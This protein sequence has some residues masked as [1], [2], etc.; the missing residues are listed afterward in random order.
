MTFRQFLFWMTFGSL[1]GWFAFV[2][3]I[4]LIDP[5]SSGLMGMAFFYL[6]LAFATMGTLSVVGMLLRAALKP[7][8]AVAR[9][10]GTSFRQSILLTVLVLGSLV[11]HARG[12]L[13]WWTALMFLGTVTISE[14]FLIS[15][16]GSRR[17]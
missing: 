8:V 14:F 10:A 9:H 13:N 2:S 16:R 17:R 7:H 3:V 6:T 1:L 4:R 11:L 5:M 15:W 12:I